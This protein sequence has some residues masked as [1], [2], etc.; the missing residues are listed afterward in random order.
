MNYQTATLEE[1]YSILKQLRN[2]GARKFPKELWDS[3]IR[4]TEIH[5]VEHVCQY[6]KIQP[7]YLKHKKC[8][9]E[10]SRSQNLDFQEVALPIDRIYS[11]TV[12]I[13]LSSHGNLKAKIQG[14][15]SCLNYLSSLF[16]E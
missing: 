5:P 12:V 16:K 4:L 14:P 3:I 10:A 7:A 9:K 2:N 1:I 11:D 6:L 13:E 15:L 8:S